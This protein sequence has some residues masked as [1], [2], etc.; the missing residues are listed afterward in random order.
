MGSQ[1]FLNTLETPGAEPKIIII[2]VLPENNV[3]AVITSRAVIFVL[4]VATSFKN[5]V[6]K[7]VK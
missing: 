4:V 6:L 5:I 7:V 2:S 1:N 3:C